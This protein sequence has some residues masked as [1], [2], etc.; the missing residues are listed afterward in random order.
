MELAR[1]SGR[2][3]RPGRAARAAPAAPRRRRG[4]A[5]RARASPPDPNTAVVLYRRRVER[6]RGGRAVGDTVAAHPAA[7]GDPGPWRPSTAGRRSTRCSRP[8][9]GRR[10]P[11]R[12]GV[13]HGG[14]GDPARPDDPAL[15]AGRRADGR[16]GPWARPAPSPSSSC[17][18]PPTSR[19]DGRAEPTCGE[20]DDP[21]APLGYRDGPVLTRDARLPRRRRNA[22][23]PDPVDRAGRARGVAVGDDVRVV[24]LRAEGASFSAGLH[25]AMLAP[26]GLPGEPDVLA[27]G[28]VGR[29]PPPRRRSRGSRRGFARL[30]LGTGRGRRRGPGPRGRARGSSSRS[31]PTCASSPTTSS[32]PCGRPRSGSCRTSGGPDPWSSSSG[33]ARALEICATGRAVGRAE[34]VATGLA[35]VAVPVAELAATTDDLVAALLATPAGRAAR[36]QAAA[37]RRGA[38]RPGGPAAGRAVGAGPAPAPDGAPRLDP[39]DGLSP[40]RWRCRCPRAR[41]GE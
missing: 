19:H 28:S 23:T 34:A 40:C 24:V 10:G 20:P 16:R 8:D 9:A 37:R 4:A 6:Q 21:P 31:P 25:R 30:A 26:G 17:G 36:A 15:R 2:V 29:R 3:R 22:Q 12:G 11:H 18:A 35:N 38:V 32:S 1:E 13:L 41:W 5:R 14:R 7:A 33:Y 27:L 39:P